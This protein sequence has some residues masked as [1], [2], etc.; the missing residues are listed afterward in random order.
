[1]ATKIKL[2]RKPTSEVRVVLHAIGGD[3][4]TSYTMAQKERAIALWL[5]YINSGK[6]ASL[7]VGE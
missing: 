3:I 5:E 1:M 4:V 7:T 6:N 2:Q